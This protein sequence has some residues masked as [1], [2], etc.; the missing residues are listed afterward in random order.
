MLIP[1]EIGKKYTFNT[2]APSVLGSV[3]T[4]VKCIAILDFNAALMFDNIEAKQRMV[5][6]FIA[7]SNIL[8]RPEKYT[9]IVFETTEKTKAV[10]ALEW[11]DLN[12][13]KETEGVDINIKL[14][15]VTPSDTVLMRQTL[16]SLGYT[17]FIIDIV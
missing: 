10:L 14:F 6:P 16:V 2:L 3:Y 7:N 11:V 1:F 5:Y 15:N 17:Q 9:F 8:D 4:K 12:S 13:I